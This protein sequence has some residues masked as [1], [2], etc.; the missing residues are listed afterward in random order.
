MPLIV[1]IILIVVFAIVIGMIVGLIWLLVRHRRAG[2][3]AL[4]VLVALWVAARIWWVVKVQPQ[5]IM[6]NR[7]SMYRSAN[8]DVWM[9]VDDHGGT[10]PSD[11]TVFANAPIVEHSPGSE[12]TPPDWRSFYYVSGLKTN[13]PGQMPLLIYVSDDRRVKKGMVGFLGGGAMWYPPETIQRL[14]REPWEV[15]GWGRPIDEQMKAELR[16]RVRVLPPIKQLDSLRLT[17]P[18]PEKNLR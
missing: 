1:L 5:L 6:M 7:T 3:V 14:I 15:E 11:L 9:Y 10:F 4:L 13:D 16:Q 18:S 8:L 17:P 2:F 12:Y